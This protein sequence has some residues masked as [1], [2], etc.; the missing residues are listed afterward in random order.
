MNRLAARAAQRWYDDTRMDTQRPIWDGAYP[1]QSQYVLPA[2][3]FI[4]F[5]SFSQACFMPAHVMALVMG[6]SFL[7]VHTMVLS[8]PLQI[9]PSVPDRRSS[10]IAVANSAFR[11]ASES[12]WHADNAASKAHSATIVL[13][14]RKFRILH[15]R[16]D[17]C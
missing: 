15:S 13:S 17:C 2:G 7:H 16:V 14:R 12:D 3:H 4:S 5:P 10:E 1:P 8:L 9:K 6:A 11:F